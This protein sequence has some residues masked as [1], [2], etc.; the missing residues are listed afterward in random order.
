MFL[1]EERVAQ[2]T[3]SMCHK[4]EGYG[5]DSRWCYEFSIDMNLPAALWPWRPL[6]LNRP[7][8][9][10]L[11]L[12]LHVSKL[13]VVVFDCKVHDLFFNFPQS[14]RIYSIK[15]PVRRRRV[16]SFYIQTMVHDVLKYQSKVSITS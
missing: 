5:F 13:N 6:G 15:F 10:F 14:Q 9:G 7:E 11:Y 4:P 2:L 8:E 1:N 3:K 16:D 12:G